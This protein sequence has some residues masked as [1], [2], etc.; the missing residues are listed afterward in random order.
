MLSN[1]NKMKQDNTKIKKVKE[2]MR[3]KKIQCIVLLNTSLNKQDPNMLYFTGTKIE[4]GSFSVFSDDKAVLLVP[5]FE[6]ERMK[7]ESLVKEVKAIEECVFKETGKEIKKKNIKRIGINKAGISLAEWFFLKKNI[8]GVKV[9]DV[10]KPLNDIREKKSKN[11]V[12]NIKKAA[13]LC[14]KIFLDVV[15]LIRKKKK[16]GLTEIEIKDLIRHKILEQNCE[17]AFEAVVAT[18]KNAADPHHTA[19]DDKIKRGFLILDFGAK[20]KEYCSDMTRTIFIGKAT[21]KEKE[22]YYNL[23]N[24]QVAAI[25]RVK[26][27]ERCSDVDG[28]VRERLGK[29]F[30]HALGHGIGIR[31]HEGPAISPK[32]RQRLEK[33]MVFTI[34]PGVY[35]KGKYG[36]RIEDDIWI[37]ADGKVEVLTKSGKEL[38]EI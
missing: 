19:A 32:S 14:D 28:F 9:V 37:N 36:I 24:L 35:V 23:L 2:M 25:N 3:D 5:K 1:K 31:I 12:E 16:K 11:E 18:G 38:I 34:E 17:E 22:E 7:K 20:Y 6:K 33:G 15:K 10:R 27:G 29:R 4:Y 21:E 26:L 30:C 13:R 8:K